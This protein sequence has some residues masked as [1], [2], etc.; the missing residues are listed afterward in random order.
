M[1]RYAKNTTVSSDKTR[2]AIERV[3]VR[4]GATGF[5]YMWKGSDAVIAFEIGRYHIRLNVPM[6]DKNS[7]EFRLTPTGYERTNEEAIYKIWEQATRQRWRAIL[8]I[9]KAKLEA[10]ESDIRTMEQEFMGDFV[11]ANGSTVSEHLLPSISKAIEGGKM[12]Q[13]ALPGP[14][15]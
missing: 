12:P 4:Y 8:L 5:M 2:M 14:G 9:I 10:V 7:D 3:L 13:L 11:L 1:A 6:P 15:D